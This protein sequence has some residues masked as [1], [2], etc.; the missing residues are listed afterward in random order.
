MELQERRR[1]LY[2]ENRRVV[3]SS[4]KLYV[5]GRTITADSI[6]ARDNVEQI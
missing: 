6:R 2:P 5:N 1:I 3:M 4:D